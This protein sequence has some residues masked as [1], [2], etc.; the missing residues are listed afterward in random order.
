M[1]STKKSNQWYFGMKMKIGIDSKMR[2]I[3]SV[4]ATEVNVNNSQMLPDSLHGDETRV[5]GGLA[6]SG[7]TETLRRFTHRA[8][9][10]TNL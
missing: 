2:L 9:D 3:H 8:N 1:H 5:W 10:F 4:A 7:Q 6:Y